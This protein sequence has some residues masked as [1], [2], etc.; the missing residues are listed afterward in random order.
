MS[1]AFHPQTDRQTERLNQT[2]EAYLRVLVS[3]EQDNWVRLLLMAEFAYN[4]SVT[5]GNGMS[6]FYA[7]YRFHPR[8]TDPATVGTL[9]PASTIYT[10]WMHIMHKE[11][12]K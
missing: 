8:S 5:T 4:H 2:I 3:H 1:T 6:P 9:N 12:T 10:H 11:S 7:N